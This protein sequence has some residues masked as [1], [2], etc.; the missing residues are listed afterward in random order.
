[1]SLGVLAVLRELTALQASP[2]MEIVHSKLYMTDIWASFFA[3]LIT[4]LV[5]VWFFGKNEN[6]LLLILIGGIMGIS[7]L[8][9][10][11]L[12][13]IF[14]PI[15]IVVFFKNKLK[16]KV[17]I[18]RIVILG[19]SIFI[20]LLPWMGRNYFQVG[21][22]GIEPQ[23]FRMV[24]ETRFEIDGN[25]NQQAPHPESIKP[26][27]MLMP[28]N[29][30]EG[31]LKVYNFEQI[32]NIAQFTTANFLHNEIHSVLIFPNS[33]FAESITGV[34]RQNNY[35]QESWVGDLNLRQFVAI[36]INL[37][38][39]VLGISLS[40]KKFGWFG[41][42][43]LS[44]H[45]FYNL[46]NGFARVS[47][48][49]YVIVTDWVVIFY[50]MAGLLFV[51]SVIFHKLNLMNIQPAFIV[52][53]NEKHSERQE[54]K[55]SN[56]KIIVGIILVSIISIGMILPELLIKPKYQGEITKDEFIQIINSSD[57]YDPIVFSEITD[58]P[59]LVFIQSK[60]FYPRYFYEGEGESGFNIEWLLA[61]ETGN[62]GFMVVS[63]FIT[64]V[65]MEL[66]SPPSNF[67]N[68]TEVFIIG[69]WN[70]S[71][72]GR[73]LLGNFI[74]IPESQTIIKS[75]IVK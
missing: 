52:N 75:S 27:P 65:T 10:I 42:F 46:S 61:K 60:A 56:K 73:Y 39:I 30:N 32:L 25:N 12:L 51:I 53:G 58:Q 43:P 3:L 55:P 21:E 62:L 14:I 74:Y 34:I 29:K 67:P 45:L 40:V 36:I 13:L 49:R 72:Y 7:L 50:Y 5:C 11:N 69:R 24:I 17:G 48:W 37:S 38:F 28:K 1:V 18:Q 33:I 31:F 26:D 57:V 66:T 35:I 6:N 70:Q 2:L 15:F 23:K 16:V 47:G 63:P 8:M 41:L 19:L 44:I 9:R 54:E 64:G 68:D 59:N 22:F 20:I 4:L 71:T